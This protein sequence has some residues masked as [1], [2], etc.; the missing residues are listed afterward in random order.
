METTQL[1]PH[2]KEF[3]SLLISHQIEYLLVGGYAVGYHGF[4]RSTVDI[5]IWVARSQENA[6]KLVQLLIAFG[7]EAADLQE[8]WFLQESR[9]FR[10]G[11]A[12]TASKFLLTSTG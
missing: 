7:F 1:P 8:E 5:D 6:R 4:P 9:V 3:L 2:S 11:V 12:P 10:M